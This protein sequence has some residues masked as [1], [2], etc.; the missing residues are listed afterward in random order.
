MV[1]VWWGIVEHAGPRRYDFSAYKRLFDQDSGER[2]E[3][4]GGDEL[5]RRWRQ[6]GGHLQHQPATLGGA[7]LLKPSCRADL[8]SGSQ[9]ML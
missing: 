3:G 8:H 4:P 2:P 1:D 7:P 5:P 6:R 9:G